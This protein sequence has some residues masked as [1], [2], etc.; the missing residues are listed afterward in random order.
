[1]DAASDGPS[2]GGSWGNIEAVQLTGSRLF[3]SPSDLTGYLACPHLTALSL[4]VARRDIPRPYR[5]NPHADL[6]ARK[7]EEHEARYLAALR[8]A[9]KSVIEIGLGEDREFGRAAHATADAIA[10]APDVVYQAVF[11]RDG[12]RGVADFLERQPDGSHEAVDTKLA[13]HARPGHLI[14]LCFYTEQVERITGAAPGGDARRV[15]AW[16]AGDLSVR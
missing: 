11:S 10:E 8:D 12:W 16:R 6:I 5:H 2:A 1:V 7:G 4:A 3:L 9:G 14:Q 13:R 15:R